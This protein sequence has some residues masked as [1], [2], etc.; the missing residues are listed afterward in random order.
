MLAKNSHTDAK[1]HNKAR[2]ATALLLSLAGV[3]GAAWNSVSEAASRHDQLVFQSQESGQTPRQQV[4][5][6]V[7]EV[8][9]DNGDASRRQG[10]QEWKSTWTDGSDRVEVRARNFQLTDDGTGIKSVA[11]GSYFIIDEERGGGE[12]Q[13]KV[14]AGTDGRLNYAYFIEGKARE[15]D[16][17][18]Q[19]WL[20]RILLNLVRNSDYAA[21]QRVKWLYEQRGISGVLNEISLLKSSPVKRA[22]FQRLIETA[23]LDSNAVTRIFGQVTRDLDSDYERARLLSD[24]VGKLATHSEL[25]S[26][27]F[28][29]LSTVDSDFERRRVLTSVVNLENTNKELLGMALQSSLNMKSDFELAEWLIE[30]A[31]VHTID[32]TLRPGF[33]AAVKKMQSSHEQGRAL[34]ALTHNVKPRAN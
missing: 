22:Y 14:T 11:Q 8:N 29:A 19:A 34:V 7:L 13:L 6:E 12:R 27:F 25:R 28:K 10:T 32:D 18:A 31:R 26:A 5:R 21:E 20:S 16:A 9:D 33:L 4:R 23:Q 15:F 30:L 2:L 24:I 17:E 3:A 1:H